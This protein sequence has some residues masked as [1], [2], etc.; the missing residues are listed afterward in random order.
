MDVRVPDEIII[1]ID[2]GKVGHHAVALDR[3]GTR[4]LDRA[5]PQD[6]AAIRSLLGEVQAQ[7]E[8]V[9]VVDQPATIGALVVAVAHDLGIRIGYLPGGTMRRLAAV[10]PGEAKT[11]ARDA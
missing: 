9:V 1:G 7:G 11:D 10:F 6:E 5:V 8:V 3:R 4:R 2:V